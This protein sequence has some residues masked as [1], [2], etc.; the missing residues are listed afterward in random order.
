MR[1]FL[2]GLGAMTLFVV[3]AAGIGVGMIGLPGQ[4]PRPG[5]LGICRQ[6][7]AGHRRA[8]GARTRC[9]TRATPELRANARPE[10]LRSLFDWAS[11][12]GPFVAYE[13]AIGDCEHVVPAGRREHCFGALRGEGQVQ[14]RHGD[15]PHRVAEAR[16]E[17]DDQ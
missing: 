15:D 3:V 6:R 14:G 9:S 10:D 12:L 11:R 1:K 2:V 16:W 17:L 4:K 7:R 5:K 8:R 13:G